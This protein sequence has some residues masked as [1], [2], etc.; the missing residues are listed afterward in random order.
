MHFSDPSDIEQFVVESIG[1]DYLK[2]HKVERRSLSILINQDYFSVYVCYKERL[3][4]RGGAMRSTFGITNLTLHC[5]AIISFSS[6]ALDFYQSP[7]MAKGSEGKY[8]EKLRSRVGEWF[9]A[10]ME[11]I[12]EKHIC[13]TPPHNEKAHHRRTR[14]CN[15]PQSGL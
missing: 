1:D 7:I 15:P 13:L 2:G 11:E 10:S 3:I 4:A 12:I 8:N 6:S 9:T 14:H 5:R